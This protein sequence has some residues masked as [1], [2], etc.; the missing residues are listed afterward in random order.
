MAQVHLSLMD[1]ILWMPL[2]HMLAYRSLFITYPEPHKW[3]GVPPSQQSHS[4]SYFGWEPRPRLPPRA[5]LLQRQVE[6]LPHKQSTWN[7]EVGF[8]HSSFSSIQGREPRWPSQNS[9]ISWWYSQ[10]GHQGP[11]WQR[12]PLYTPGVLSAPCCPYAP[13]PPAG[14]SV[15]SKYRFFSQS[16]IWPFPA[17]TQSC[18]QGQGGRF[19][20]HSLCAHR[21]KGWMYMR[22]VIDSNSSGVHH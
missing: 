18:S 11:E 9:G 2:S 21:E 7:K 16:H 10:L 19:E 3:P 22:R 1:M 17:G 5:V 15:P 4:H 13:L 8:W 20:M 6:G 14:R 12:S